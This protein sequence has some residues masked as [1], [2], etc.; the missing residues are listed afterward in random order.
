MKRLIKIFFVS[1][2]ALNALS[3]TGA[4]LTETLDV[5]KKFLSTPDTQ[6]L[7][8]TSIEEK[9]WR[10]AELLKEKQHVAETEKTFHAELAARIDETTSQ[11]NLVKEALATK[12]DDSFLNKKFSLLNELYQ[13]LKDVQRS[14]EKLIL[15]IDQ[16]IKLLQ[17]YLNDIHF[18]HYKEKELKLGQP[19]ATKSFEDLQ[20]IN[21]MILDQEKNIEHFL[22]QEKNANSELENR[23]QTAAATIDAYKTK[24]DAQTPAQKDENFS[25]SFDFTPKQ[26]SE[27]QAL[28]E[29]LYAEKK[30]RDTL[31]LH[32]IEH[33]KGLI[34]TELF[35]ARSQLDILKDALKVVKPLI[36]VSEADIAVAQEELG[37]KKQQSFEIKEGYR[38]EIALLDE[39]LKLK[40]KNLEELSKRY[41]IELGT[42]LN[43]WTRE[44][45]K[46]VVG[47]LSFLE[48]EELN[49][50]ILLLQ[51]KKDLLEAQMMLE[52][53]KVG[54]YEPMQISV[55]N[56][57]YKIIARKFVT[58]DE[59]RQEKKLY[60]TPKAET[61][62]NLSL[63]KDRKSAAQSHLDQQKKAL[64]HLQTRRTEL[65][66][67]R[68]SIFKN[69][70]GD[71]TRALELLNSAEEKI[72]QQIDVIAKILSSDAD[73]TT[74]LKRSAKHIEFIRSELEAISIWYRPEHAI[75]WEGM[76]AIIPTV[77]TFFLDIYAYLTQ[78][79]YYA[80]IDHIARNFKNLL[81]F[82]LLIAFLLLVFFAARWLLPRIIIFLHESM[83]RKTKLLQPLGALSMVLEF[84]ADYYT[85][86]LMWV[87]IWV[88][89]K[90]YDV[91]DPHFY[92]VLYLLSIPYLLLMVYCFMHHVKQF[93]SRHDHL[94]FSSAYQVRFFWVFS[95]ILYASVTL[96][97][98]RKAF[99]LA[100]YHKSELPAILLA[101]FFI[102]VQ[103]ALVFLIPKDRVLALIPTRYEVGLLIYEYT[104]MYYYVALTLVIAIMILSNPYVGFGKL[105]LY[106]LMRLFYSALLVLILYALHTLL[107]KGASR[108]FFYTEEGGT[109]R[110]R[111]DYGK[112]LYGFFVIVL[113]LTFI[114]ITALG[115]AKIWS[116]PEKLAQMTY[117][118]DLVKWVKTPL[119]LE[120][121]DNPISMFSLIK[122]MSFIVIGFIISYAFNRFILNRVFDVLLIEPGVQNT[123]ASLTRYMIILTAIVFGF[124][125]VGLGELVWYLI[126]ALGIGIGWV[127]KDPIGDFIAYF[128]IL[129]QRPV[130][131]GDYITI[132]EDNRGVV[133]K[134]TP[135]SVVIRRKNS[136]TLIVPNT[137]VI[138]KPIANWNY[139]RG[140][141]AFDDIL[142]TVAYETD[143]ALVKTI[144]EKVV[145]QNLYL[146]KSPKPIVRLENFSDSGYV[147]LVRGFLSSNYTLDQWDIASD[148]RLEI[149]KMLRSNNIQLIVPVR[150]IINNRGRDVSIDEEFGMNKK[151]E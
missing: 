4:G 29:K 63:L 126:T 57:F 110:E 65:Q 75:S 19:S 93:N 129:V 5:S 70:L 87:S 43:E 36:K 37:K 6:K 140:F 108:V 127:M 18:E 105:V 51:R 149:V 40:E 115:V 31:L 92:V 67:L 24:Q 44:P 106:I 62:A 21:Q 61:K 88:L 146:L 141:I 76:L 102:I 13:V 10:L 122:I 148:V 136:T 91:S 81:I 84:I 98:F 22:E 111:F 23:K 128:I 55:K 145:D 147:F 60:D 97:L 142:V 39:E 137:I 48:V 104:D 15:T 103:T 72:K 134:I 130:K 116:W 30:K 118:S 73:I 86:L 54:R 68:T 85:S 131:I 82:C 114:F 25:E 79:D 95:T 59:I 2:I 80:P 27:L 69:S 121:T 32:E 49:D 45:V 83:D 46:T 12:S 26:R 52:D 41:S 35:I 119:M 42:D 124:Q 100:S 20:M 1:V 139:A 101:A 16:H 151:M 56:S 77:K 38:R 133:R 17:D 8:T 112:T 53:E 144:L 89:F 9:E 66:Q 132:D 64:E 109:L 138:K 74:M 7:F 50:E 150:I 3:M 125:S 58:D 120:T 94:F 113:F 90:F 28:E 11:L 107:K 123:I 78:V 143:P 34:R 99:I 117:W 96:L 33:K 14:R 71:Y 135:R 47:Y